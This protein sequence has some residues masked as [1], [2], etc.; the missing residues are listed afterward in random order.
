[1]GTFMSS[2][3]QIEEGGPAQRTAWS[4]E[5]IVLLALVAAMPVVFASGFSKY[6]ALKEGVLLVGGA[7]LMLGWATRAL[8]GKAMQIRGGLVLLPLGVMAALAFISS[9]WS[10]NAWFATLSGAR[11]L[12]LGAVMLMVLDPVGRRLR[13]V[14]IVMALSI[15]VGLS[16]LMGLLQSFG[17][18]LDPHAPAGEADGLRASFDH[19][20][21][22]AMTLGACLPV[23]AAG[24]FSVN[25][26]QRVGAGIALALGALYLGASGVSDAWIAAG[27]GSVVAVGAVWATRSA[28]GLIPVYGALGALGIASILVL[29]GGLGLQKKAEKPLMKVNGKLVEAKLD[30]SVFD[31]NNRTIH[32]A[33]WGRAE[34][35]VNSEARKFVWSTAVRTMESKPVLGIG[36]G[37]WDAVQTRY[38]DRASPWYQ[39]Q[40]TDYPAFRM[41]HNGFLQ[42]GAELGIVGLLVWISFLALLA[43]IAL[44][45]LNA[46]EGEGEATSTLHM[47]GLVGTLAAFV[48]GSGL[49]AVLDL[50]TGGLL[51]VVCAGVLVRE[52]V[53]PMRKKGVAAAWSLKAEANSLE[54]YGVAAA[55]PL[56]LAVLTIYLGVASSLSDFYKAKGDVW[57]KNGRIDNAISA[58]QESVNLFPGQDLALYNYTQVNLAKTP[59]S[60]L[61]DHMEVLS[62][63]RPYD[64]RVFR[65]SGFALL[66]ES[67][68]VAREKSAKPDPKVMEK[69]KGKQQV[70]AQ[71]LL[72]TMQ[73][74]DAAVLKLS[75]FNL[76][77]AR[78]F[79][80]RYVDAYELNAKAYKL[81]NNPEKA[82]VVLEKAL[83]QLTDLDKADAARFHEMLGNSYLEEN[84][85]KKARKHFSMV[86]E[87]DPHFQRRRIVLQELKELDIRL[88]GKKPVDPHAGH[89]HDL[90]RPRKPKAPGRPSK[91]DHKGH[92][93]KGHDHDGHDHKGHDHEGHD[94]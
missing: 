46:E 48:V 11:W 19:A 23:I 21:Y 24:V 94:H 51:F 71:D 26:V 31:F 16:S 3:A 13:F 56:A 29:G 33:D 86:L 58:Y 32:K 15:G 45:G 4:F 30:M 1:M 82:R 93:H 52:A 87:L 67:T 41:A 7:L 34:P 12:A 84:A 83:S 39:G 88:S 10:A 35:P 80:P 42:I 49:S 44:R 8:R 54:R 74:A 69:I 78:E 68:R 38:I 55:V 72:R 91:P 66:R 59:W 5:N 2:E 85:W 73:Q 92:D 60:D 18:V 37:N 61:K 89:N 9:L 76:E 50:A 57:F 75:V 64:P 6:E 28:K 20:R 36:A 63:L 17:V 53:L 14:E 22:A 25:G 70:E 81:Q 40:R 90:T 65:T 79:H 62:K 43:G 27:A 47:F 77:K